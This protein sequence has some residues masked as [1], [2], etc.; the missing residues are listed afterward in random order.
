[1]AKNDSKQL[2]LFFVVA[3]LIVGGIMV[4]RVLIK[5]GSDVSSYANVRVPHVDVINF[6][7][8]VLESSVTVMVDF[9]SDSC[10]PCVLLA[11][12][13]ASLY[14]EYESGITAKVF[15]LN[16]DKS[17]E[18]AVE[19]NVQSIPTVIFFKDGREIQ[20]CIGLVGRD[21]LASVITGM[22]VVSGG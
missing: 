14:K 1:M 20:R 5:D 9:Y 10:Q 7:Q 16:V 8:E 22:P 2:V 19:Y 11:P 13:V 4:S 12:T 17:P 18:I 21:T 6:K 15:K 3:A